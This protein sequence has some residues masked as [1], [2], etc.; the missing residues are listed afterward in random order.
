MKA[1]KLLIEVSEALKWSTSRTCHRNQLL[2][3][4]Y[5]LR[6]VSSQFEFNYEYLPNFYVYHTQESCL[7]TIYIYIYT[8]NYNMTYRRIKLRRSHWCSQAVVCIARTF[9]LEMIVIEEAQC[10]K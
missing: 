6:F 2:T 3:N 9:F 7:F 10:K 4:N 1:F 5:I 8:G